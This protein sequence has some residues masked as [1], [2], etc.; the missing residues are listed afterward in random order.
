MQTAVR[1]LSWIKAASASS[2]LGNE[3]DFEN[4]S[5][6]GLKT[7]FLKRNGML[8]TDVFNKEE[9]VCGTVVMC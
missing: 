5:C 4:L 7:E 6:D 9:W 1:K 8:P 3:K 2:C